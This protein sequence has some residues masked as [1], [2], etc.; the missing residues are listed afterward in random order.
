VGK[1]LREG[2]VYDG[3]YSRYRDRRYGSRSRRLP[4]RAFVAFLQNHDQIGNSWQ[5]RRIAALLPA[6]P[7]R[8]AAALLLFSPFVPMLFMGEEWGETTPFFY[9]TSHGDP[10]LAAAV[11]E[12]RRREHAVAGDRF[13]DPDPQS[14]ETF[15]RCRISWPAAPAGSRAGFLEYYRALIACRRRFAALGNCRKD[16][17]RAEV[18]E[19]R[20]VLVLERNDPSGRSAVLVCNLGRSERPIALPPEY[21]GWRLALYSEAREFTGLSPGLSPPHRLAEASGTPLSL[22]LPGFSAALFIGS[23]S[24]RVSGQRRDVRPRGRRGR[25]GS[26]VGSKGFPADSAAPWIGSRRSLAHSQ[27]PRR[28]VTSGRRLW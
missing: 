26:R 24:D 13:P 1:A 14:P 6:G 3:R 7:C 23:A 21:A 10:Q 19:R 16:L 27:R 11:R 15:Q 18:D 25:G 22:V 28:G 4:G 8:V 5:G 20:R 17:L 9:F 12:G 2:F